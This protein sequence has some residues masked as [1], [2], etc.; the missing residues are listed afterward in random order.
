MDFGT[1][2]TPIE[3]IKEG[4]FGG[5][6]FRDIYSGVN[7]KFYN[8]SWK[9]FKELENIDKKYYASDFYDVSLNKYGVS[10]GWFQ[11]YFRYYLGRRSEND[12]RQ[13]ERWKGIASRFKGILV[14]MITDADSKFDG[15][16]VSPKIRKILLH[17]GYELTKDYAN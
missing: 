10:Y 7:D 3:I 2:K 9:E 17:W 14:K 4:T 11:W 5:T 13:M 8:N 15:Y 1:N 6:Y 16:S 12:E